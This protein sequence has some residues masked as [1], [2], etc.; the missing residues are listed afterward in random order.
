MSRERTL[1]ARIERGD[2]GERFLVPSC[3]VSSF[4]GLD[5]S[6]DDEVDVDL[7]GSRSN[8]RICRMSSESG[9]R[10]PLVA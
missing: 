5:V 6:G 10:K 2:R 7:T 4:D 1:L 3:L 8:S 9:D